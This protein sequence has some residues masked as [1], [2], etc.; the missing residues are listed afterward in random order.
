MS[1]NYLDFFISSIPKWI[2]SVYPYDIFLLINTYGI[3]DGNIFLCGIFY[4]II[5]LG[6]LRHV[7][8]TIMDRQHENA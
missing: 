8:T 5:Q 3:S 6:D 7:D 1:S 2:L 4:F